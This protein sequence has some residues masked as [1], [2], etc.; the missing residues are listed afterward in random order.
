MIIENS[1]FKKNNIY[2]AIRVCDECGNKKEQSLQSIKRGRKL[3]AKAIDLCHSCASTRKYKKFIR[4][5]GHHSWKHGLG[6]GY[7]RIT[8]KNG[9]RIREHRYIYEQ[10]LGRELNSKERIHH[11]DFD[12]LN[13]DIDNLILFKNNGEHRK[14]HMSSMESCVLFFLGL[15]IWFDFKKNKYILDQNNNCKREEIKI[16]KFYLEEKKRKHNGIFYKYIDLDG[17]KIFK[18]ACVVIAE[19]LLNRRLYYGEVTHHIDGNYLNNDPNNLVV[20]SR[21]DH[22]K[23]HYSLQ[24]CAS[25]FFKMGLIGFNKDK[26]EYYMNLV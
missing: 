2:K 19:K 21:K 9:R 18:K 16:D 14:C 13:N 7:K 11:I 1:K 20:L 22:F 25:K 10:Y 24:E 26:K 23:T 17:N 15:R 5:E 12:K 3:R 6:G 4:G 8:L